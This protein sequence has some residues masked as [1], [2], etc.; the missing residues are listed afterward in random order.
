MFEWIKNI[1]S[2]LVSLWTDL[3]DST[4]EKII[5]II[6]D[7]SEAIFKAYYQSSKSEEETQNG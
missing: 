4:K 2:W 5:N 1:F 3:P 7:S 6:V